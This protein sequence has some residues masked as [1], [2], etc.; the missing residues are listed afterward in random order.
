LHIPSGFHF[1]GVFWCVFSPFW[2]FWVIFDTFGNS[3][4]WKKVYIPNTNRK[5]NLNI[6]NA[7]KRVFKKRYKTAK[8]IWIQALFTK[9]LKKTLV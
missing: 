4:F 1:F 6:L 2:S 8:S 9:I 3:H 5:I 7:I